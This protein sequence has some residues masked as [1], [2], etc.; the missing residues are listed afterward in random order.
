VRTARALFTTLG[1]SVPWT[2]EVIETRVTEAAEDGCNTLMAFVQDEGYALWPSRIV[3]VAPRAGGRDLVRNWTEVAHAVGLRFVAQWMGVHVQTVTGARHPGWFQRDAAG[4]PSTVM[5][6]NSPFG[7]YLLEQILEVV[8]GYPIDGIYLD[9]LYSRQGGCYC[10]SCREQFELLHG[11]PLALVKAGSDQAPSGAHWLDRWGGSA[12][13]DPDLAAFRFATV[14][15]FLRRLRAA[16]RAVRPDVA[17]ILDTVGVQ[18]GFWPNGQ[19]P[20]RLRDSIDAFALECYPDQVREPLW[21]AA[22]EADLL[23]AEARR[24]IWALRWISRDPDGDL[25]NVPPATVDAHIATVLTHELLPVIVEMNQYALD[26]SLR[27]TVASGLRATELAASWRDGMTPARFATVLAHR[28]SYPSGA[29]TGSR[30]AWDAVAGAWLSLTERQLPVRT[31][32]ELGPETGAV[33]AE[34]TRVLVVPDVRLNEQDADQVLAAVTGG[35]GLV[36]TFRSLLGP[37]GEAL[38]VV[39]EGVGHRAGQIGPEAQGGSELVNYLRVAGHELTQAHA[40]RL[41]SYPG[42]YTRITEA[43]G[44]P[45][46][47]VLDPDYAAMDGERWFGWLPGP[48]RSLLGAAFEHGS[49]RVVAWAAPLDAVFYRQGR[50]EFAE[51]L[52]ESVRWAARTDPQ[53]RVDAPITVESRVWTSSDSTVVALANRSSNDLYAIGPGVSL[54]AATSS[55]SGVGSGEG[56]MRAQ[57]P[58]AFVPIAGVSLSLPWTE[59][60][61]PTVETLSGAAPGVSISEG[62]LTV[63]LD[64][65]DAYEVVRILGGG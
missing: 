9:G 51:L 8:R 57:H 36:A 20:R 39:V 54:G 55:M 44:Q 56:T 5:C 10:E 41:L 52:A 29:Q 46:G 34:S 21:H 24:P 33:D 60:A 65:L 13:E 63:S 19:D 18:A 28:G 47:F 14:E 7:A 61:D 43:P 1:P 23:A 16:T 6:V 64:R 31:A 53:V 3:P 15:S 27:P 37:L 49:G 35:M 2:R 45:L 30:R 58:R 38:G 62:R 42:G 22:F 40:G 59:T 4:T 48:E 12:I 11:R 25:V 17:L 32:S 26:Q 50:P